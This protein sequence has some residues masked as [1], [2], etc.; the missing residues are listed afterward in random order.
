MSLVDQQ[1]EARYD[2]AIDRVRRPPY[3]LGA[4]QILEG[5]EDETR[6]LIRN[7]IPHEAITFVVGKPGGMKSWL[8]FDLAIK[9][10]RGQDWLGRVNVE[11]KP[12]QVL[13]LSYDNPKK[14]TARRFKRLGLTPADPILFHS[15][16]GPFA[17]KLGGGTKQDDFN[18][19]QLLLGLVRSV[20]PAL[21]VVDSFRQAQVKDENNSTEMSQIMGSVK[22]WVSE[23]SAVVIVHHAA[24]DGDGGQKARGSSEI[25]GSAD[26]MIMVEGSRADWSKTRSWPITP[27]MASVEFEVVDSGTSTTVRELQ[28]DPALLAAVEVRRRELGPKA[29]LRDIAIGIARAAVVKRA[30]VIVDAKLAAEARE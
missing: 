4:G 29:S 22:T 12:Q 19:D 5:A 25:T 28:V 3:L 14:E 13:V 20:R 24:S 6:F 9:V 7:A 21:I 8:A 23:G 18:H 17:L 27:D 26:G 1:H 16:E 10:A 11:A 2:D 15:P 30:L